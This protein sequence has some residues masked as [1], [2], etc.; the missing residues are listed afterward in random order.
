ME[1]FFGHRSVLT[2]ATCIN[3]S[4][5]FIN[6]M[7]VIKKNKICWMVKCEIEKLPQKQHKI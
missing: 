7:M 2:A 6:F 3:F 4:F 1:F 5:H